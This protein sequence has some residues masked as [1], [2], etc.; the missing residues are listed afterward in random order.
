MRRITDI[1]EERFVGQLKAALSEKE[2]AEIDYD[3][4]L[5]PYPAQQDDGSMGLNMGIAVSLS[6]KSL[7]LADHV[8]INGMVG[9]PY[10]PDATLAI[11][12]RELLEALRKRKA[13]AG[14]LSNGGLFVPGGRG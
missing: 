14:S 8:L 5:T 4:A 1:F 10:A 13:E 11:N 3:L 2:Q 12:V 9:D 7:T 6:T